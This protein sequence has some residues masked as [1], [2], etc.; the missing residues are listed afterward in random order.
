MNTD[1]RP[2]TH[3][4]VTMAARERES[5]ERGQKEKKPLVN[6]RTL[7][8]G[9]YATCNCV[10]ALVAHTQNATTGG[11]KTGT[12]RSPPFVHQQ[13]RWF[14][15]SWLDPVGEEVPLVSLEPQILVQVRIRDLLQRL[16]LI[17]RDQMTAQPSQC[18]LES[19][20]FPEWTH[21]SA[22]K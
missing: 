3:H 4:T 17:D 19:A 16:N 6:S 13:R 15:I 12:E 21:S 8:D 1:N 11:R 5:S 14:T 10:A 2:S 20:R 7:G 22:S 18:P 9:E